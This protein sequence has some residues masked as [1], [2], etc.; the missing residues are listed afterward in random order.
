M[1]STGTLSYLYKGINV[2][3]LSYLPYQYALFSSK[4]ATLHASI[5][6]VVF[7]FILACGYAVLIHENYYFAFGLLVS[8]VVLPF[9]A[10]S[11]ELKRKIHR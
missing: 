5:L 3:I 7:L 11:S 2:N 10:V 1:T 4:H 9:F 8:F 6:A